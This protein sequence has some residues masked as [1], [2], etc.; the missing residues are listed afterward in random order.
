MLLKIPRKIVNLA[1][2]CMNTT[3]LKKQEYYI[4]LSAIPYFT[5]LRQ[6]IYNWND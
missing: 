2:I 3:N 4:S 1:Q 6:Y 5:I